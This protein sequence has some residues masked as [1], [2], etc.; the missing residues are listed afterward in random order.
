[1]TPWFANPEE[2]LLSST[3]PAN[4]FFPSEEGAECREHAGVGI[5]RFGRQSE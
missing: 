5:S 3:I 4:K 2:A 1:M